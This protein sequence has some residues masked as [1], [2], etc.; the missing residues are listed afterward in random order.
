MTTCSSFGDEKAITEVS[1]K[2]SLAIA[3]RFSEQDVCGFYVAVQQV[4][5]V[6]VIQCIRDGGRNL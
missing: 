3:A 4:A 1:Q 6:G 5:F 2:D